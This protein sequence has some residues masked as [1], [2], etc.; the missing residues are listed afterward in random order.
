MKE[1]TENLFEKGSVL[2][3]VIRLGLPSVAGQIILVIYNMADTYFISLT[4]NEVMIS[5]VTVSMPAFMVLSALSNLFGVGGGAAFSR[6]LG[7]HDTERT[8]KIC[9]ASLLCCAAAAVIYGLLVLVLRD[10]LLRWLGACDPRM[11]ELSG[12][13]LLITTSAGALFTALSGYFAH[14]LRAEGRSGS[15]CM[16]V[17]IGGLINIALDPVFMFFVFSPERAVTAVAAATA[18]SNLLSFLYFAVIIRGRSMLLSFRPRRGAMSSDILKEIV[19]TGLPAFLMTFLENVSYAVMDNLMAASGVAAQAGIGVAKKINMLAHSIVRGLAQGVLPLVAYSYASGD[20]KRLRRTVRLTYSMAAGISLLILAVYMLL[21]HQLVDVFLVPGSDSIAYGTR[22]L[23]ILCAG[24]PF[25]AFAYTIISFFQG[26]GC[27][28]RSFVLAVLRKGAVDV[29]LM[30]IFGKL[31]PAFGIA[32]ATPAADLIC[33]VC[34]GVLLHKWFSREDS[35]H[36][37]NL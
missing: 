16:G 21:A 25:S 18:V 5:A 9:F 27:S 33:A 2:H 20:R 30:F 10:A 19:L 3:A 31:V 13:Y 8:E 22:F 15:A 28:V 36:K 26:V 11:S 32:A 1:H 17:M 14:M 6:A 4:E 12:Q 34:A 37:N 29:P 24:C 35:C 23:R 7:R